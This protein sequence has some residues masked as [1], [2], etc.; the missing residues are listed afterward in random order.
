M[1]AAESE[2]ARQERAGSMGGSAFVELLGDE[3]VCKD[4]PVPTATALAGKKAVGL[5]FSAHWYAHTTSS[6]QLESLMIFELSIYISR[7]QC[8]R[9][10]F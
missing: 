7:Q 4:G 3:L 8:P 2:A 9:H 6:S 1:A 10:F 5:Y